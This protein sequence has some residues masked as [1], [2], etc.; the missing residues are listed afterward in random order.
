[1]VTFKQFKKNPKRVLESIGNPI[2]KE[3]QYVLKNNENI[4][5]SAGSLEYFLDN[6]IFNIDY[7]NDCIFDIRKHDLYLN[8]NDKI[9]DAYMMLG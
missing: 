5:L 8:C 2:Y 3:K 4:I 6:T 9:N 7:Y 1:M